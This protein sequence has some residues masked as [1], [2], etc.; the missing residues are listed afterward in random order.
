MAM[1]TYED[2]DHS[3]LELNHAI[4]RIFRPL[5]KGDRAP[6]RE[7]RACAV[8]DSDTEERKLLA[9]TRFRRNLD[10]SYKAG[11]GTK[12]RWWGPEPLD[13]LDLRVLLVV[14]AIAAPTAEYVRIGECEGIVE[15]LN[16]ENAHNQHVAV[17]KTS[18]S[19]IA[20]VLKMDA[21]SGYTRSVITKSIERM[22]ATTITLVTRLPNEDSR[23]RIYNMI[24]TYESIGCHNDRNFKLVISPL[25]VS[26]LIENRFARVEL[27]EL[28]AVR[29]SDVATVLLVYLSA[30]VFPGVKRRPLTLETLVDRVYGSDADGATLRK[31]R[32]RV[33]DAL[34]LLKK[35]LSRWTVVERGASRYEIGRRDGLEGVTVTPSNR[36]VARQAAG[37]PGDRRNG[38]AS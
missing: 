28:R 37:Q 38:H 31:R 12:V 22:R 16:A 24:G 2:V 33:K 3:R 25:L 17:V 21:T 13:P 18:A 9:D 19:S 30:L 1:R 36:K 4:A 10:V 29:R 6:A 35:S 8:D 14:I 34:R 26:A 27:D 32:A 15:S 20:R 11:D 5:A 7:R 23:R